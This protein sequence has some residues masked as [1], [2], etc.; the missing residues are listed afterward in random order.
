MP[1]SRTIPRRYRVHMSGSG[2]S[3]GTSVRFS[4]LLVPVRVSSGH[5]L[6]VGNFVLGPTKKSASRVSDATA[7]RRCHSGIPDTSSS[8]A[9]AQL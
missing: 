9:P 2:S 8:L 5:R 1:G 7:H 3:D 6:P 4:M